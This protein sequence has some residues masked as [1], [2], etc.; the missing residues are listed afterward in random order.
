V[1]DRPRADFF[2]RTNEVYVSSQVKPVNESVGA[3]DGC[4]NWDF[5]DGF[6]YN[7]IFE[8]THHYSL[9][10]K[11]PV[12][13]EVWFDHGNRDV[14]DD[15]V[16]D[17]NI[18]CNDIE[19][20]ELRVIEGGKIKIPNAFTPNVNGPNGGNPDNN[21]TNDV[22]LPIMDGV[23]E[24]TMQIFDRWGNLIFQSKEKNVG[25][26]GYDEK[27]RLMPAGVYVYKVVLRLGDGERTTKVGDVT[28]IR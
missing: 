18:V 26:D 2:F 28:L 7:N 23:E 27:G 14:D 1:L 17:G 4:W 9:E 11:Y 15:G 21:F 22:F 5:G 8:P 10:G 24:F 19:E 25:W 6:T 16:P 12:K 3:C 20:K 13:L